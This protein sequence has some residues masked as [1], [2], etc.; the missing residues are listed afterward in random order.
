MRKILRYTLLHLFTLVTINELWHNLTFAYQI[1]TLIKVAFI[2]TVFE[3]ILKPIVKFLLLPINILTLGTIRIFINT[4]GLYLAVFLLNDF[5]VNSISHPRFTAQG[6]STFL[7]TSLTLSLVF[8]IY[9]KILTR[10]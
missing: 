9:N 4:L 5:S 6:F 2:L 10:K 3:L 7:L 1:S 8:F